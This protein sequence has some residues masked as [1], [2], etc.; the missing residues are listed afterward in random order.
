M[1]DDWPL[2]P[3]LRERPSSQQLPSMFKATMAKNNRDRRRGWPGAPRSGVG[4]C[5]AAVAFV[6][7]A[8]SRRR[9]RGAPVL[10]RWVARRQPKAR[11]TRTNLRRRRGCQPRGLGCTL[12]A[13]GSRRP[14]S[15]R[16][17]RPWPPLRQLCC[18]P[19]PDASFDAAPHCPHHGASARTASSSAACWRC[20][21]CFSCSCTC[22]RRCR[23]AAVKA[24][25][26]SPPAAA[27]G[28]RK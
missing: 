24:A 8:R 16:S 15:P 10:A 11:E 13:P 6:G 18:R 17:R 19:Q 12:M 23:V 21:A 26:S 14:G 25:T 5:R 7:S 9:R 28:S 2:T 3:K 22:A 4:T 20:M 27:G 1:T